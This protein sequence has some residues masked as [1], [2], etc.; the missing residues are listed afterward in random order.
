MIS[1]RK[2]DCLKDSP[3]GNGSI[4]YFGS[5]WSYTAVSTM[6]WKCL[7]ENQELY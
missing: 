3:S 6:N 5:N 4:T 2:D 1:H 7:P